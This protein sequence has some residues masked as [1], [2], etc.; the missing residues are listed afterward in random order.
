MAKRANPRRIGEM[1]PSCYLYPLGQD[2]GG[3]V[4]TSLAN[5]A[6]GTGGWLSMKITL[7]SDLSLLR[8]LKQYSLS[9]IDIV[10]DWLLTA[11]FKPRVVRR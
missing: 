10:R 6:K 8:D 9:R 11:A 5:G 4:R 1:F 7:Y 3:I 2:V